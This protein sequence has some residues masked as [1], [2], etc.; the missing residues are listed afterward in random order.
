MPG[1]ARYASVTTQIG[2]ASDH[3]KLDEW[4]RRVGEEEANRV[5]EQAKRRGTR[6]HSIA[7]SYL[8]N[9]PCFP[10]G[11]TPADI[12]NF[13]NARE[14]LDDRVGVVQGIEC[15]LYSHTLKTAGRSDVVAEFDG[16]RSIIDF[17]TSKNPKQESW[18][19]GY[20]VQ[21]AT[22]AAMYGELTGNL[23]PQ[24]VIIIAVDHDLPQVFVKRSVDY[25]E[26]VLDVFCRKLRLTS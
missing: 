26:R 3:T 21:A 9:E 11:A 18:I 20:F 1:G 7:E 4:R 14:V 8:R 10:A 16:F 6:F 15:P 23:I 13:R 22:Y 19:L 12:Q 17:K 2:E 24:I 25:H 5:S